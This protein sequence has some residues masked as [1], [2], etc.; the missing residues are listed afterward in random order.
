MQ[1]TANRLDFHDQV[2][3]VTGAGQGIGKAYA[4][5]LAARGARVVINDLGVTAG[6]DDGDRSIAAQTASEICRAGGEAVADSHNVATPEGGE[7][8]IAASLDRWGRV[9]A[10]IANAGILRDASFP[11]LQLA[12]LDAVLAVNLLSAF[13][14]GRPAFQS[15]K[16]SGR[17]GRILLTT[18][19]AGLYGN[20]GQSNYSA[21]KMGIVGLTRTLGIE[22]AKYD[23]R[24]NALAPFATTRLSSER[25][26]ADQ[27]RAPSKIAPLAAV[28]CH[29]SCP[30]NGEI[31]FAGGGLF[32]RVSI[33][34]SD[35]VV[36]Q[37][38]QGAEDL[39]ASWES[40]RGGPVREL[41]ASG[42]SLRPYYDERMSAAARLR[43]AR[44]EST[45]GVE[46]A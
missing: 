34:I 29:P 25:N 7:A 35:G 30:S 24:I 5:E 26:A 22:G 19:A 43:D 9:D 39:L 11:K 21:A 6:G 32:S 38:G 42:S 27:S 28:L 3:V 15:M 40:L 41:P 10:L 31:F 37:P 36:L 13:Y 2:V 4:M 44:L 1:E 23:I 33:Q 8:L 17:G 20:F 18:S 14:V 16:D 45:H 46:I 12:N